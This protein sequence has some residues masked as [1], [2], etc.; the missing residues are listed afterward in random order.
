MGLDQ[1]GEERRGAVEAGWW[2]GQGSPHEG[3]GADAELGMT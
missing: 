1:R 3:P 2:A